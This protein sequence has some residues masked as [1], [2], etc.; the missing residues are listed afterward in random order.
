[1]W[2]DHAAC[3]GQRMFYESIDAANADLTFEDHLIEQAALATCRE[4]PSLLPCRSW[5]LTD[6]DPAVD[7]VAGGLT[8]RQ[9]QE[10]RWM[11]A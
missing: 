2:R 3:K 6:P 5:A 7:H 11:R 1:M 4:C 10:K 9:R 8:P